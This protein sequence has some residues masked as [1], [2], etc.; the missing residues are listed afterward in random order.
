MKNNDE[1]YMNLAI[2]EAIKAKE[3]E[4][5]P[6]GA[7][8]VLNGEVIASAHNLRETT[9]NAITH[10]EILA[11]QEACNKVESWRLEDA[12]LYVT[13]E[14]CPMCS[15]AIILSRIKRVVYGA[16]DPKA[17]C[18]GTLMNL[19]ND[20]RFNHQSEVVSGVLENECSEML[21]NFFKEIRLRK[22]S[23]KKKGNLSK[24]TN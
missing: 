23:E 11:I 2:K 12:D 16:S 3:K 21:S 8:I 14:P 5:V 19:L 4:E 7:V 9:Q 13:L 18:A 20:C 17:G 24:S 22:K 15:G 6:I 10:A 1:Y